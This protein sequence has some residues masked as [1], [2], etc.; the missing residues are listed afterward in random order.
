MGGASRPRPRPKA[1]AVPEGD[2]GRRKSGRMIPPVEDIRAWTDVYFNR[3]KDIVGRF[4]DKREM[5]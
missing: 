4:G 2:R 5:A 1:A 3:T